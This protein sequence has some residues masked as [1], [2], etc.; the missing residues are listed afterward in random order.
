[1]VDVV[2]YR[3]LPSRIPT[4]NGEWR[5]GSRHHGSRS[6]DSSPADSGA[7]EQ[8]HTRTNP[9]VIRD[10]DSSRSDYLPLLGLARKHA[11]EVGATR[12]GIEGVTIMIH[13]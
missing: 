3:D 5:N 9:C 11:V 2:H 6:N 10:L 4:I 1:M 7:L 12:P 13:D 8:Y